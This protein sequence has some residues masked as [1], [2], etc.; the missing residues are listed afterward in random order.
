[1][2]AGSRDQG[3]PPRREDRRAGYVVQVKYR[4][5]GHLLVHYC[6]NL[7]RGGVF[8]SCE[9][10]LPPGSSVALELQLPGRDQPVVVSAQV[11]WTRAEANAD[12]P[13]GMGLSFEHIERLLG[14]YIDELVTDFTPLQVAI[15]GEAPQIAD[16][17]AALARSL[18]TCET[19]DYAPSV[20]ANQLRNA[21][22]VIVD[23]DAGT[24]RGLQLLAT[25]ERMS[26]P[27]PALAL[28]ASHATG[29]RER[30][31]REHAGTAIV[32]T[33]VDGDQLQSALLHALSSITATPQRD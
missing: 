16:R 15:V 29:T 28:V 14:D 20:D 17:I 1:M 5:A 23:L 3:P 25:L 10:P 32:D 33:P 31:A 12:G 27:P 22:V 26:S 7:S 21:D 4:N 2:V 30:I 18:V 24:D 13:P 9:D 19:N 8:V 11:R 6:T